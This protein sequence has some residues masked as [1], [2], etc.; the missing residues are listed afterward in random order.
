[1]SLRHAPYEDAADFAIGLKPIA[2]ADW[3][4]GGEPDP[5][6]RKDPLFAA[7]RDVV[8]GE[9]PASRPGQEEARELVAAATGRPPADEGLPPLHAA[10]RQ[11]PDDLVLMEKADG[12][13]R[14]S[15]LS[16]CAPTFFSAREV[17]G[18]ALADIH[19]PVHGFEGRFLTRV[20]RIFDGLRP[21]LILERRNWSVVNSAE[22]F[23][24]DPAPIRARIAGIDP[25]RAGAELHVRVERQT[26]RRLP[27][28]GGALFTIRVW[29]H[30]LD[31]LA[32]D[33]PRL[34]AFAKAWR[35]AAA[36]FR[37][38]KRLALY[39]DLVTRFLRAHGESH[40]V[41]GN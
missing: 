29:L 11:V 5:A 12:H 21:G 26:L 18:R 41:N 24:P 23:T 4:E 17:L 33:P 37:A 15:A 19:A 27:R 34:A 13:W 7:H 20:V 14:V 36:D 10:A 8:W 16:L 30:P 39:D 38:Y 40:S 35:E 1:M 22:T 28:T 2:E 32:G 9:T 31:D 6:A 25:A 3:L